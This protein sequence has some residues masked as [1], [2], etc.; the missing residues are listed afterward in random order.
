MTVHH[1]DMDPIGTGLINGAHLFAQ[2]GEVSG[3]NGRGDQAAH[4][5]PY[6]EETGKNGRSFRANPTQMVVTA[7]DVFSAA[8]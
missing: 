4:G 7:N 1:V 6:G 3:K 8:T 5:E 2:L